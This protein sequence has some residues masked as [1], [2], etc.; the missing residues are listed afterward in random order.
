M[1]KAKAEMIRRSK[2]VKFVK[3]QTENYAMMTK[4]KPDSNFMEC[5]AMMIDMLVKEF[6]IDND[7]LQ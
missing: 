1:E 6:G 4:T 3:R 7:E 2:V 5:Y